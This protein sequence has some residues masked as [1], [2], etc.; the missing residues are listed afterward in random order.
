MD[1]KALRERVRRLTGIRMSEI[2]SDG[3]IDELVNDAYREVCGV[4]D[5]P[6]LFFEG[7]APLEA[8]KAEVALPT[9]LR[10][11]SAAS[12]DGHRLV[13]VTVNDLD[14]L[15]DEPGDPQVYARLDDSR[16]M[17]WPPPE[18]AG[19]VELRG[20][21]QVVALAAETDEPVFAAEFHPTVAYAAASR[22]LV[23]EADDTD[24]PAAFGQEAGQ[25]ASAMRQRYMAT[26][27]TAPFTIGG[28]RSS[29]RR[30]W[31]L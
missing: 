7:Q 24:R 2:V 15:D 11:V 4:E 3:A 21:R 22:L 6:F 10:R 29:R 27:D 14:V 23:E 1:K 19:Q 13:E 5:W 25:G 30:R 20:Y 8:G 28:R 16:L 26:A 12:V 17:V 18:A 9:E 31:R